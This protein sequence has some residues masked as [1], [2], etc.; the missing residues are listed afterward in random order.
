MEKFSAEST[1]EQEGLNIDAAIEGEK[2]ILE[3]LAEKGKKMRLIIGFITAFSLMKA[4]TEVRAEGFAGHGDQTAIEE[5]EHAKSQMQ[6]V[7]HEV[8]EA[9]S[10]IKE[11]ITDKNLKVLAEEFLK[12]YF[13]EYAGTETAAQ[14]VIADSGMHAPDNMKELTEQR[15]QELFG[16]IEQ[17]KKEIVE[18]G[19]SF[20]DSGKYHY[21]AHGNHSLKEDQKSAEGFEELHWLK[22][23]GVLD[24][25]ELKEHYTHKQL[26]KE[27]QSDDFNME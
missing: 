1:F 20:N 8:R 2:S 7:Q 4:T 19:N 22:K 10:V 6:Q 11:K 18:Q 5:V 17:L 24:N 27:M 16:Q 21:E 12:D 25:A 26:D 23:L 9:M 13:F 14:E 3:S 15:K